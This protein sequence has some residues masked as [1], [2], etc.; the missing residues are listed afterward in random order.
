MQF[1]N[2]GANPGH[3]T[4]V[5]KL[6][7]Q[8]EAI[9][10]S[11][12][13]TPFPLQKNIEANWRDYLETITK[14]PDPTSEQLKI[15]I[16]KKEGLTANE[17]LVG[18]GAAQLIFLIAMYFQGKEVA[19]VE[20]TFSE[21]R[22]ACKAFNCEVEGLVINKP[23]RLD[24]ED[25]YHRCK[26]KQL[27][28]ICN[29]NNPTGI[30]YSLEKLQNLIERLALLGVTVVIDEA[31]FD[32]Q[33]EGNTLINLVQ[34]HSNLIVLRSLTKMYGI[35]GLRLG[36]MAANPTLVRKISRLQNPWSVNGLA[37][38]I[39]Y[40]CLKDS[41]YVREVQEFMKS[42]RGRVFPQLRQLG[43]EISNSKVNFYLLKE[44]DKNEDCLPL[45]KFLI[46]SGI[47]PRH[48]YNFSSLDGRYIR[49]AIKSV[50]ENNRLLN[51][52]KRW[53]ERC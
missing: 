7:L 12:N 9:D 35:A 38:Q 37:Q 46:E 13:T 2:H 17:L 29:P 42:E 8:E 6:Q 19:I 40:E 15:L 48:T 41:C 49:L 4:K 16:A 32:F 52:L 45:I 23:W 53:K 39:G 31:F 36:F 20:P 10:F 51:A 44:R 26:S 43:Y 30:A 24:V 27:L 33:E 3:L 1:P 5:L 18:N 25:I 28:F 34:K 47:I 21:Y 14:Y 50:G 11:V 22:D